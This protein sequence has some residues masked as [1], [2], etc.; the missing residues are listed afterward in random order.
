MFYLTTFVICATDVEDAERK[1]TSLL[2]EMEDRGWR[3]TLPRPREWKSEIDEL[4][5]EVLYEGVRPA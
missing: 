2:D 3:I 5:L 4:K 1:S